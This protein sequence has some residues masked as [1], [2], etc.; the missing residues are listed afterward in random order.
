MTGKVYDIPLDIKNGRLTLEIIQ[1]VSGDK[2]TNV[3]KFELLANRHVPYKLP[4][5][6]VELLVRLPSGKLERQDCIIDNKE[7]GKLSLTLELKLLTEIGEHIAELQIRD[8]ESQTIRLTTP[9]FSYFVR[10][11]LS[12]VI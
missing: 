10:Q 2:D 4:G 6:Q 5:T 9:I 1:I 7:D 8:V 11:S 12:E 3:F